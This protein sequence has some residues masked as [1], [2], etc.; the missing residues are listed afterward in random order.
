ME[1]GGGKIK[2]GADRHYPLL[3]KHEIIEEMLTSGVWAPNRNGCHL[4]LWITNNHVRDGEFVMEALGFRQIT[5]LTWG[6]D[7][8][9]LGQYWR[10]QTE[11][12]LFGVMGKLPALNKTESTLIGKG[13]IPRKK[14]S[15]KPEDFYKTVELVSPGPSL[16]MFARKQRKGWTVWGN[17]V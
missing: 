14:H 7:R 2:R 3:L 5:M 8:I 15:E 12:V 16:E 9:G 6:K 13:V 11:H 10:G 1:R 17:E 4:Y